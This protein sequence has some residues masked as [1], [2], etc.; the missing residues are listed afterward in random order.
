MNEGQ[1]L[2]PLLPVGKSK[3]YKW[4]PENHRLLEIWTK[5]KTGLFPL[6]KLVRGRIF[7]ALPQKSLFLDPQA[8]RMVC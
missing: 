7:A 3:L 5:L 4:S 1:Q 2:K 6:G 8:E